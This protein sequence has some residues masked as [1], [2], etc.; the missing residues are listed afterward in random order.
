MS[1]TRKE[2]IAIKKAFHTRTT[3]LTQEN[4]K[5]VFDHLYKQNP[6]IMKI[7]LAKYFDTL[8]IFSLLIV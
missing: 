2:V 7:E 5:A 1:I 3:R 8:F 4:V 6:T